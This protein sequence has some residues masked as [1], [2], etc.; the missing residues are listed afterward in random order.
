MAAFPE[1]MTVSVKLINPQM[2]S[3]PTASESHPETICV[4]RLSAIGDTCH[5][6]AVV[7]TL[8]DSFPDAKL[9]W[10][11]GKTEAALLGDI[12]DIEFIIFDKSNGLSAYRQLRRQL[13]ARRFDVCLCMHAS[14]RANGVYALLR[15]SRKIGFDSRRARD[16]QWLFTNQKIPARPQQ[17]VLDG[18]MEFAT[19]IGANRGDLRWNI[20]LDEGARRFAREILPGDTPSLLISPCSSQRSRNYRNWPVEHYVAIARR[21][22]EQYAAK[23]VVTGGPSQLEKHYGEAICGQLDAAA[24]NLV[25]KTSLKQLLALIERTTLVLCPDSGPAHMA[26]AVNT[27]VVGLYA[28][29]NPERTGPYLSQ[30]LVVNAYPQ[31]ALEFC[32]K[33]VADLA[34]GERIRHSKAMLLVKIEDVW[35]KVEQVLQKTTS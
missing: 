21:A 6:L 30:Q 33:T 31:A 28:T 17:H 25:G 1:F 26:T 5:A 2:A 35:E 9:T 34:W 11:I 10:I 4:V 18:L 12:P 24:D 15:S 7:R 27:P 14:M 29:S 16:F 8:Q 3:P 13:G 20:P 32:G 19:T 23:I 22:R